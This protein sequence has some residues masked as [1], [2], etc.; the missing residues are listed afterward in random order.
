MKPGRPPLV[1]GEPTTTLTVRLPERLHDDVCKVALHQGV[2][3]SSI[4]RA[5]VTVWL[6]DQQPPI[7]YP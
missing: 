1:S 6:K 7:L 5:A 4:L 2:S 3:V